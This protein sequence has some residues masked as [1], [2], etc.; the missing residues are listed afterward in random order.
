MVNY[1]LGPG[2]RDIDDVTSDNEEVTVMLL[3][4]K[5]APQFRLPAAK[6][7]RPDYNV[8]SKRNVDWESCEARAQTIAEAVAP[9]LAK[10]LAVKPAAFQRPVELPSR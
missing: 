10:V 9:S 6:I 5:L 3:E 1:G 4:G 2:P 8:A 7:A